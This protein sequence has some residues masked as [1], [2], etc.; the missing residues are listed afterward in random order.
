M[1]IK[2]LKSQKE[3]FYPATI[4]DAVK[5]INFTDEEGNI[6]TQSEINQKF[7]QIETKVN[8]ILESVNGNTTGES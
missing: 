8:E 6:L 1:K 3:Y 2:K 4:A 5:D 7:K